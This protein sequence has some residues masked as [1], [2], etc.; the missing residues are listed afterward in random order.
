M[1]LHLTPTIPAQI[2]KKSVYKKRIMPRSHAENMET[3]PIGVKMPE[4]IQT[5]L[6]TPLWITVSLFAF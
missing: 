3:T 1:H 6:V 2:Y 4:E 5:R